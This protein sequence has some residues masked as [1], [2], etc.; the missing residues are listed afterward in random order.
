MNDPQKFLPFAP[1]LM[2]MIE[3]ITKV[4][5]PK[6][7]KHVAL[8]LRPRSGDALHAPPLHAGATRNP[9]FDPPSSTVGAS[10]S[11][12]HGHHDTFIKRAL[13][14]IFCMCKIATQEINENRHD[15]IEIKSHL[16]LPADPY[17]E[18]PEF[19]DPFAEWD[20]ADKAAIAA[21]HAPLPHPRRRTRA[22]TR[23][24]RSPP[25]GQEIF[26]EDEETE[27]EEPRDYREH[28]DSNEDKDTSNEDALDD[29]E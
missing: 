18:L 22:P 28:P 10:S 26:D 1:Y 20:A 8:H 19:D 17:H 27:D 5:F 7:C 24:R 4:T 13:T 3:R 16:R 11:S 2:Y 15:I 29:D 14:S 21:A 23:S 25:R 6:D 12:R 9:R